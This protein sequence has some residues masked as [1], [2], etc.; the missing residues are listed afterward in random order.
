MANKKKNTEEIP[1]AGDGEV[2]LFAKSM[3]PGKQYRVMKKAE[4][5]KLQKYEKARN[6]INWVTLDQ[7]QAQDSENAD[8]NSTDTEAPENA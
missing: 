5:E 2:V 4:S 7:K 3:P 8:S 1:Q 6:S